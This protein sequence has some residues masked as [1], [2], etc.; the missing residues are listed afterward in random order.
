V[1]GCD[2]WHYATGLCNRHYL[3]F[4][5]AAQFGLTLDQVAAMLVAQEGRCAI[6]G[7]EESSRDGSS[8]K[9]RELNMDHCH[10]SGRSRALLCNRCNRGLG[11]FMD[12]PTRLRAAIAYL[13]KHAP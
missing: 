4:H 9:L 6:C 13:E 3:R 10:A 5:K 8:G 2:N 12:D 1:A 11:Y 7:G